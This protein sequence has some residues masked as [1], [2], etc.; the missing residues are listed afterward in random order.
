MGALGVLQTDLQAQQAGRITGRATDAESGAPLS[1]V[2]IYLVGANIGAISRQNG[3]YVILNVP[4]GAY[5][6]RAERIG[7]STISRQI[8]VAAGATLEE[9]FELSAQALGLD[10]IVVTGTAGAA[11]RREVGNSITT[12]NTAE[13]P[14][15]PTR[16]MD[17]LTAMAPG[18][19]VVSEGGGE[20]GQGSVITIR[21]QNTIAGNMQKPPIIMVDG[22]RIMND[23]FDSPGTASNWASAFDQLNPND[24][25]RVEVISGPAA[26]TL[27]GTEASAGVIQV[28]TKRGSER[29]PVWTV[30]S[31][32]G[33]LWNQPFGLNGVDYIWTD[34]WLCT[35]PF[36]CGQY[37]DTPITQIHNL[38]VRGGAQSL[39]YY[40]SGGFESDEGA[41]PEEKLDRYSIRGNFTVTPMQDLVVQWN[42]SYTNTYQKNSPTGNTT[43]GLTLNTFRGNQ[44]YL[45]TADTAIINTLLD[46]DISQTIERFTTG[47][48]L[49]Y[50]PVSNLTNRF[51]IGYDFS[52]QERRSIAPFGFI[53][54]PQG[55]ISV[56]E[57]MRRFLTFDYVGTYTFN[58][59]ENLGS[60]FSWGGQ[61]TGDNEIEL[62]ANAEGFPGAALPTVGSAST[63]V[64]DEDRRKIWNSGFFF[65]NVFDLS[66]KYFLTVGIRVDGNSTFGKNFN[67]QLYPKASATWVISDESFWRPQFGE[68]KLRA[69]YG[70]SGQAPNAFIAQ[71]TWTNRG[72]GGEPAF[73]PANLGNPDI[74][75]EVTSEIEL[76]FDASWF[77]DRVRPRYTYY[78]QTT[79][80]AI[81]GVETIPSLGFTSDVNFN[82]GE[83]ENWGHELQLDVSA[84]RRQNFGWEIGTS[85]SVNDN[86]VNAW[87]GEDDPATS[88]RLGRPI[89]YNTWTMYQHEEGMGSSRRTDGTYQVQTCFL[90]DN[91]NDLLALPKEEW[92]PRPG[93]DPTI[94]AC[95]FPSEAI[96]GYPLDR[97]TLLI[98]GNTTIRLPFGISLSARADF[99]GG[100]GY[101]RS[102]N[103]MGSAIGRNARS[104]ACLPYY[105]NDQNNLLRVD[106]PAIWVERCHSSRA[107]G[108]QS[109]AGEFKLRSISASFPMDWLFPDRIQNSSLFIVMNEVYTRN[110]SLW[111]N[112][113]FGVAERVP[114]PTT[115]RA[116]LRITF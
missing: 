44:N 36:K 7:L 3:G 82:V 29:A 52:H 33:T 91:D 71:R 28:F 38:S 46:R 56:A 12:I 42:S 86:V 27:Y 95:S 40:M 49:T 80:D 31:Q 96:Y 65:Q 75:P 63:S 101:W 89:D 23:L 116:A 11:T 48:T 108:Y 15:R 37:H 17:M 83:V 88:T 105:Q 45:A 1:D 69:A 25:E 54:A 68:L 26:S 79:K 13:L 97:P 113:P 19:E 10:E 93:L 35:A 64:A 99:R 109:K 4:A 94:H 102:I 78:H 53:P 60:S 14:D 110:N 41:T 21:G 66:S 81:Q 9:N 115:L 34:P 47:G 111:S 112:Y 2:Q 74:G 58:L 18:M 114:A 100:H 106:T 5:E 77:G 104:P 98:N 70:L 32:I 8:T 62:S 87:V 90:P 51:T 30:E 24:I 55:T 43:G 73:I 61:A 103:A 76:G 85:F 22:V 84:V 92:T 107:T 39:Q 50:S 59:M 57:Y 16:V 20:L 72:L 6:I 67:L